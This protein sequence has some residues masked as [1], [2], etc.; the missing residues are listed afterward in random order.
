[1]AFLLQVKPKAAKQ[2]ANIPSPYKERIIAVLASIVLNP[3]MGKKLKGEYDGSYS[4]K[5]WPYR[6][7][8][9]VCKH[10]LLVVVIKVK[11]RGGVYN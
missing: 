7:I 11:H 9:D 5:V 3:Y 10:Q 2:L 1:M 4:V 8:Y 6:V